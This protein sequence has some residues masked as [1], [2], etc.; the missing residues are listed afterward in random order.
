MEDQNEEI[1]D[2]QGLLKAYNQAKADLV[3]L[4]SE[5]KRLKSQI[6]TNDSDEW[7]KRAV[8][9]ETRL[10]LNAEGIK[11]VDRLMNYVGTDGIEFDDNGNL[12]G[13]S[14]RIETLKTDLPELFDVK[15]RVGGKADIFA[16]D[17]AQS[18]PSASELQA[19]QLLG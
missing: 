10:A 11:D 4:R 16:N 9:A 3:E 14:E 13:L 1:K 5:N 6:E 8:Q 18:P 12:T 2:P 19:R 17:P 15:R 7:K